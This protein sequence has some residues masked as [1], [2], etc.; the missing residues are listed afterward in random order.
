M[1]SASWFRAP[2][3]Q[4]V[5]RLTCG[6]EGTSISPSG[7]SG[8]LTWTMQGVPSFTEI[9]V[10][11]RFEFVDNWQ[12]EEGYVTVNGVEIWRK[13]STRDQGTH[14]VLVCG[15]T[16]VSDEIVTIE[17][18]VQLTDT[19][20]TVTVIMGGNPAQVDQAFFAVAEFVIY[21]LAG[22]GIPAPIGQ[23]PEQGTWQAIYT[24]NF[25]AGTPSGWADNS[26]NQVTVMTCGNEG[27]VVRQGKDNYLQWTGTG[28]L[29]FTKVRISLRLGFLDS[30]DG[31]SAIITVNDR[32]IWR[33]SSI[34]AADRAP[35]PTI[36]HTIEVC[37]DGSRPPRS[38]DEFVDVRAEFGIPVPADG[39][40][41]VKVTSDL[42]QDIINESY[43]IGNVKI[44]LLKP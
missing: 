43:V 40:I 18:R 16:Q 14:N 2:A 37:G 31:E 12:G 21:V 23:Q 3:G 10:K 5:N 36:G 19:A 39:K 35:V 42:D 7:A 9:Y 8:T 24:S 33:Q 6:A 20:S 30:W 34:A 13:A 27:I 25:V 29:Q 4:T 15:R 22:N 11:V 44:E 26:G 1:Q 17:R 41:V 28:A 32:E 38:L